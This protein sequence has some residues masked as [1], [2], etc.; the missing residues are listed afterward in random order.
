MRHRF[1]ANGT[2]LIGSRV[3]LAG[4]EMHHARVTRLREGEEIELFDGKGRTAMGRL[5]GL[6]SS[7]W[8]VEIVGD[9]P[10]RESPRK[11]VL[12]M[13]V[14]NLDRFELVLQKATELGVVEIVPLLTDRLEI[15]PERFAGKGDRWRKIM[16]EAVKQCGRSAIP[17]LAE[18]ASL[19][20]VLLRPGTKIVFDADHAAARPAE[21]LDPLILL[22]GPEGGWSDEELRLAEAS[23]A[24]F[25]HLGPRRL[26]AETAAIVATALIGFRYGDLAE[27]T[28]KEGEL[29]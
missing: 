1:H 27:E 29:A 22:I 18:N 24:S 9:A 12:A 6:E 10:I 23:G 2:L 3:V 7:G 20:K 19:S 16:L 13:A 17:T 28:A 4:E 8:E 15:R 26:R 21:V 14:I 11:I 5:V 25:E